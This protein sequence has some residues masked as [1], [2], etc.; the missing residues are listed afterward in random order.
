MHD[1]WNDLTTVID[2]ADRKVV[3]CTLS[4]D[5]TSQSTLIKAWYLVRNKRQIKHGFIFHS[6]RGV[7]YAYYKITSLFSFN[8]KI[9]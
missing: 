7:N 6:D 1:N 8:N 2:L 9:T 5:M 4:E 3:S